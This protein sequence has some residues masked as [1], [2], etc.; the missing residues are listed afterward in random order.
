MAT[1]RRNSVKRRK[2][3]RRKLNAFMKKQLDAKR[4]NLES[5][6]YKGKTYKRHMKKH[7]VFYKKA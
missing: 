5:F 7:L 3:S 4:K 2:Q 6:E 1:R